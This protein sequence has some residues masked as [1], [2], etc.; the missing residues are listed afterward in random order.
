MATLRSKRELAAQSKEK[1]E[2]HPRRNLAQESNVLSSQQ[3]HITQASVEIE[4]T[5]IK[6]L[7]QDV[8]EREN[9]FLGALSRLDDFLLKP[10]VQGHSGAAPET[11]RNAYGTNQRTNQDDPQKD[12]HP[13]A[14]TSESQTPQNSG[15]DPAYDNSVLR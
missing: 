11:S 1:I 7:S 5:V 2:E 10:L 14:S 3:E 12:L 15:L 4:V 13:E 6:K 8:S 9:F